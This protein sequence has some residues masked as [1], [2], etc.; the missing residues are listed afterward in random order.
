MEV[1]TLS[2]VAA[3]LALDTS[4]IFQVLVSQP[5][6]SGAILGW[7]GGDPE[8]GLRI[9]FLMQ[10]LWIGNLPVGAARVP[11]SNGA[12]MIATILTIQLHAA[13]DTH[14]ETIILFVIL[15]S[16]LLSYLGS[17]IVKLI[18]NWNINLVNR[19]LDLIEKGKTSSLGVIVI[20]ALFLLWTAMFAFIFA[21][22]WIGYLVFS[23]LLEQVPIEWNLYAR[24]VE[25]ALL[26]CGVG[27]TIHLF[28]GKRFLMIIS[29]AGAVGYVLAFFIR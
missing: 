23:N 10:L 29:I 13:R 8:L 20:T 4:A 9:G 16:L 22:V 17:D 14:H 15:Y 28:R 5:L 7:L 21:G 26:G 12:A 19:T 25:I 11:E 2:F 27:L 3:L 24:Y 1:L 18:R 6:I